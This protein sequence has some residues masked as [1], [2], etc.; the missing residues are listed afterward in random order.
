[1]LLSAG[2]MV[3]GAMVFGPADPASATDV[4]AGTGTANIGAPGLLAPLFPLINQLGP[5][6]ANILLL[7]DSLET[8]PFNFFTDTGACTPDLTTLAAGGF[9]NGY[10]GHSGGQATDNDGHDFGWVSIG[11]TLIITG[12]LT[13]LAQATP[14]PLIAN[15]SCFT[16]HPNREGALTFIVAGAVNRINCIAQQL[17]PFLTLVTFPVPVTGLPVLSQTI[18]SVTINIHSDGLI[19]AHIHGFL[20]VFAGLKL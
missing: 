9:V 7:Q 2:L 3:A 12:E 6:T 17:V 11:G 18:L 8:L 20:H 16:G 1:M 4:C 15:N 10:C 5:T 19:A 14:N 13:G